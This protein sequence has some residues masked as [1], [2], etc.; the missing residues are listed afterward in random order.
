MQD[1][2]FDMMHYSVMVALMGDTT[3][4]VKPIG[5]KQLVEKLIPQGSALCWRGDIGHAGTAHPGCDGGHYRLF[6]HVDAKG[7]SI[8]DSL[9]LFP[10]A[11]DA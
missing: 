11:Y 2:G 3:L 6:M 5:S 9:S 7:R 1:G 10:I 4:W 8:E